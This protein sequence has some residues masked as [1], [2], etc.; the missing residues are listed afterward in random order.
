MLSKL[1]GWPVIEKEWRAPK[2]SKEKLFG[3]LRG[4]Y[5]ES[6]IVELFVG[7]D[8]KNSSANIIQVINQSINR[9]ACIGYFMNLFAPHSSW[10]N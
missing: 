5:S 9:I 2:F 4:E 8:D 7:A 1:G 3:R 10:T 6:V